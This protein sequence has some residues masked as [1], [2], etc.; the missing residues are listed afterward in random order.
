MTNNQD[1]FDNVGFLTEAIRGLF[2]VAKWLSV[3]HWLRVVNPLFRPRSA[4]TLDEIYSRDFIKRRGRAIDLYVTV[5]LFV[6]LVVVSI[7]CL[8]EVSLVVRLLFAIMMSSRIVEIV[9]V[10]V[11]ATLFDALSGRPDVVGS[12]TRMMVL[13]G[14]NFVELLLCFGVFMRLT[15]KTSWE[16]G[17]Q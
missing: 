4:I 15:T 14:L 6:E 16:Q 12:P 1:N 13:A 10:T 9:Q 8:G 3:M 2:H 11:N 5:W 7:S 17:D